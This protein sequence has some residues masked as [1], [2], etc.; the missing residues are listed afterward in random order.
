MW[1]RHPT[2]LHHY[3]EHIKYILTPQQHV[4][5]FQTCAGF[6]LADSRGIKNKN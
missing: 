4:I 6:N 3:I 5:L 2:N 1:L